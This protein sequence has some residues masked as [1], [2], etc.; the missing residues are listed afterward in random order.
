MPVKQSASKEEFLVAIGLNQQ[1]PDDR[2][3]FC[4][5]WA[6]VTTYWV[7]HFETA[8][9]TIL[10]PEYASNLGV[11]RP[12][13]W[14]HLN[15]SIINNAIAEI[16]RNG[17]QWPRRFYDQ[18]RSD[19]AKVYNWVLKWLL[20]H[21]CRYRDWRNRKARTSSSGGS[22][23]K[24]SGTSMQVAD[25]TALPPHDYWSTVMN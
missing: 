18:G 23:G 3:K 19:D 13:K 6:E 20:W 14:A 9:R 8:S 21:V 7:S 25:G 11:Q 2:R 16:W 24:A 5:M 22:S 4:A 17:Q 12:Y 10:K 15:P 1:D